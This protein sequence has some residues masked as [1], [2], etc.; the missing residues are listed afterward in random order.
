MHMNTYLMRSPGFQT[1]FHQGIISKA[2]D[3]LK[4]CTR[5]LC[6]GCR[7]R[8]LLAILHIP[9]NRCINRTE[10]MLNHPV[11][12]CIIQAIHRLALQLLRQGCMRKI[13]FSDNQ[14]PCCILINAMH[15]S[16]TQ[17]SIDSGEILAV[18]Q[19]PVDQCTA[20]IPCS[21]VYDDVFRLVDDNHILILIPHIQLHFLRTGFH[22]H[23]IIET[24]CDVIVCLYLI[25][26]F[27][28]SLIDQNASF[29]KQCL[30]TASG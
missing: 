2:L 22:F 24:G 23:F 27:N 19:Q 14:Q 15:D 13:I 29:R 16:R 20:L 17:R 21:R 11:H 4:V 12:Q 7:Y 30:H 26:G 28:S 3:H 6:I 18:I 8:H 25:I 10:I 1:T 5:I 9:A